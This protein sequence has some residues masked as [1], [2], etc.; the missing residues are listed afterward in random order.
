MFGLYLDELPRSTG[1]MPTERRKGKPGSLF[2]EYLPLLVDEQGR[3]WLAMRKSRESLPWVSYDRKA[4][5]QMGYIARPQLARMRALRLDAATAP[6]K[7]ERIQ[8][9]DAVFAI[10]VYARSGDAE[11]ALLASTATGETR[12]GSEPART[13]MLWIVAL[14]REV[15][16][17]ERKAR[18][19][20]GR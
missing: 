6:V 1:F 20:E 4:A 11:P 9:M 19:A 2:V 13:L 3:V 17:L 5:T 8:T 12:A 14:R 18:E 16:E 15:S 10:S 7:V